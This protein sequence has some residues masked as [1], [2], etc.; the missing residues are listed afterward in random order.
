M[1]E[2][3]EGTFKQDS[4]PRY[5]AR[6]V[7]IRRAADQ[8]VPLVLA[9]ATP[10]LESWYRA[11]RGEFR[12]VE[13]PRRVLERP[14]PAVRTV[15]LR[16]REHGRWSRGIIS[17][18]LHQAMEA[19]LREGGQV[20]LLLNRRG[21]STHIQ[22][23]ACGYVARCPHCDIAMTFHRQDDSALCHLCDYHT[24]VPVA[25]PD[26]KFDGLRFWGQGTQKLEA[27]V[28]A[29]FPGHECLRMDTDS[30]RRRGSHAEAL[31]AFREG[32]A[33]ILL[34][35]QMIAKG[36]DFPNVTLVGVVSADY[37]AASA[38]LP[39]GRADVSARDAGGGPH[40]ARAAGRAGGGADVEPRRAGDRRGRA[41]RLRGLCGQR[42]ARAR[43]ARLSAV[44][45]DGADR[46][47]GDTGERGQ[48]VGR[49]VGPAAARGG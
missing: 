37:G 36:L 45:R 48:G 29:R 3:H 2:E 25:C 46:G 47:A 43:G 41:A 32:R 30:M 31:D 6:D 34:G 11:Q 16:N 40:G 13:M 5:H 4:A 19:A 23:P 38:R 27:E 18:P 39:R 10:S 21:Y 24:T 26:C 35:T 7:A 22:C 44:R 8:R 14:L 28:R 12:L 15:D 1:D 17:R 49:G 9:S 20:I 33:R 42:I